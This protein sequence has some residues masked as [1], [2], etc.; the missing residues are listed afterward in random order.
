MMIGDIQELS[1][2]IC[3]FKCLPIMLILSRIKNPG[4]SSLWHSGVKDLALSLQ[5]HKSLLRHC[6]TGPV[7]GLG[8]SIHHL[9]PKKKRKKKEELWKMALKT[10]L[11]ASL[12]FSDKGSVRGTFVTNSRSITK[13]VISKAQVP[14]F[15]CVLGLFVYQFSSFHPVS[16]LFLHHPRCHRACLIETIQRAFPQSGNIIEHPLALICF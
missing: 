12:A 3:I 11:E 6:G 13:F 10:T 8:T 14:N 9:W 15:C 4:R 16:L 7:P 5:C 2:E 1:L